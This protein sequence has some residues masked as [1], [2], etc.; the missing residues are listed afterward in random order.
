MR[1][2][3]I[4]IVLSSLSGFN[5]QPA[6][7]TMPGNRTREAKTLFRKACVR[8]HG[9]DGRGETT[10]GQILGATDFTDSDWQERVDDQRLSNAITHGKG[11]MPGFEKKLTKDQIAL[12]TLYVR[13]FKTN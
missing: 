3:L 8:C 13:T 6:Q 9:P 5:L 7:K 10:K 12:L 2:A 4:I 1:I 11:D